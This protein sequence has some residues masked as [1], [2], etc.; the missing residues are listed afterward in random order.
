MGLA[1]A[2]SA[3][4]WVPFA[5]TNPPRRAGSAC[6]PPLEQISEMAAQYLIERLTR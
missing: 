3:F 5:E 1:A 4:S 6:T 2:A